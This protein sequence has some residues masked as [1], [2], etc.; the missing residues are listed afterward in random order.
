MKV[1]IV[2]PP[3]KIFSYFRGHVPAP[4]VTQLAAFVRREG[5]EVSI[6]DCNTMP[7]AWA[8]LE[9]EIRRLKPDIVGISNKSTSYVN[10]ALNAA[11]LV[12][13]VD[14][15]ITVVGG[16]VHFSALPAESLA[17]NGALDFIVIGEGEVTFSKLIRGL[18]R[19]ETDFSGIPGLAYRKGNGIVVTPARRL[20][21]DL[22]TLPMPAYNLLPAASLTDPRDPVTGYRMPGMGLDSDHALMISTSRGCFGRCLFCS[23]TAFWDHTWRARDASRIVDEM[24]LLVATYGITTFFFADSSFTWDRERVAEFKDELA[25]RDVGPISFAFQTR[26]EHFLRDA[27]LI[28]RLKDRGLFLVV[29]GIESALQPILDK[30]EKRQAIRTSES[31]MRLAKQKGLMLMTTVMWG[32]EDDTERDLWAT[33][34]LVAPYSDHLALQI[35]TPLPGTPYYEHAVENGFIREKNWDRWDMISPVMGTRT[36][37]MERIKRLQRQ[38]VVKFHLSPRMIREAYFSGNA[39]LRRNHAYFLRIAWEE[40]TGRRWQTN[41]RPFEEFMRQRGV[42]VEETET[43]ACVIRA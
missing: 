30:F 1:C 7:D 32:D 5:Y 4:A 36:L 22:N 39:L 35:S 12:K 18:E 27:D 10:S 15:S 2:D 34:D 16:G 14:R 33:C 26:A 28:D 42:R 9:S 23:E 31:A 38:A 17:A 21:A 8:G 43:G 40:M 41:W 20:I 37:S 3:K 24:E 25:A 29:I 11:L 19:K 13:Q 6:I